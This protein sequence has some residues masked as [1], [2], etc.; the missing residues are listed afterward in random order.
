MDQAHDE[1]ECLV[2]LERYPLH[3]LDTEEGMALIS[4]CRDELERTDALPLAG[5]LKDPV[6]E[7][8]VQQSRDALPGSHWMQGEFT[9]YSDNLSELDDSTLPPDHPRRR[10]LPASHHFING[11]DVPADSAARTLYQ[12]RY[13][14]E[15]VQ[16]VLDI[17]SLYTIADKM[18]CI[19]L[20][21]YEPGDSNGWHFD[22][23]DFVLSVML[24]AAKQGGAYQYIPA[25][26]SDQDENLENVAWRMAHPDDPDGVRTAVLEPGTLFLFRGKNTFHRVTPV[27]GDSERIVAILS[28]HHS[29]GH[30][31]SE[32][33]R[34]AM[35][36]RNYTHGPES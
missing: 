17:P 35:Y 7:E 31:L 19:N 27:E 25:L 2:N 12:N 4:R 22:T 33:S 15:F 14:I 1:L 18:G 10:R 3:R 36:G 16:A 28:Y 11:L 30:L 8:L 13:F 23:T 21:V 29:P 32:G 20:L 24:K 9:P 34:M 5:F 6:V 26:R